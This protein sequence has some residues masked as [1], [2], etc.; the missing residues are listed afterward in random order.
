[1]FNRHQLDHVVAELGAG[2]IVY[3]EDFP[4]VKR[5]NVTEFLTGSGLSEQQMHAI[6]HTNVEALLGV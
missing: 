2:R 5:D 1:M 4:D 3:S 6:A